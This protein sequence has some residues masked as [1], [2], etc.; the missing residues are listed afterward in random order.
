M[1]LETLTWKAEPSGSGH[2][3]WKG[4]PLLDFSATTAA[5]VV[6]WTVQKGNL[7]FPHRSQADTFAIGQ[8]SLPTGDKIF[9]ADV[10]VIEGDVVGIVLQ[11]DKSGAPC[12]GVLLSAQSHRIRLIYLPWPGADLHSAPAPVE[13][14]HT[15]HLQVGVHHHDDGTHFDILLDGELITTYTDSRNHPSGAHYGVMVNNSVARC[16]RLAVYARNA[17][18]GK[19]A[20]I[21]EDTFTHATT[22]DYSPSTLP[23]P[24]QWQDGAL[25]LETQLPSSGQGMGAIAQLMHHISS[26]RHVW[27]P[28]VSPYPDTVIGDHS[29]RSPAILLSDDKQALALIPDLDDVR[30]AQRSGWHV[31]LDYDHPNRTLRVAAGA[32]Q[33]GPFHVAYQPTPL[34]YSGQHVR[35]RLHVLI[36]DKKADIQNPYGMVA[37]WFWKQWGHDGYAAGG[38]QRTSF[39]KYSAYVVNWAFAPEPKGWGDTVWQQFTLNGQECGAPAFIVD[40]AQHPSV[41]LDKRRWRE[42]RSVWNQ[43]W[44][45]TQRTANGLL[46]YA[47]QIGS[48]DLEHRAHLMT[49]VALSAPQSDGLFPAVYTTGGGGYSLYK[50]SPGWEKAHWTNSDRRPPGVSP[51]ACHILDAA[52]TARLLLEWHDLNPKETAALAYVRGFVDRLCRLQRP[53]GAFPGWIEPNGT[54]APLLAEGPESAMSTTLLLDWARRFPKEAAVR[55]AARKGLAYLENGP[56]RDSRWEDFE[57][58]FSCSRWGE[59][60]IG[61]PITRN[62]VYKSNTFSPFWCAEAFLAASHVL[63]EPRYL[64]VGRR[65]LDELSLYQQVWEPPTIPAPTHGGFGVMNSD[66]EWNDARQSLFAPLY[67]AYYKETGDSEYFERG[68]S[69]LRASF[70]MMYCPENVEVKAAYERQHPFFGPESYGFMMENI[71]HGGPGP[72]PIGPFT[73]FTWG[74]GAALE[75]ASNVRDGYGDLYLDLRHRQVFGVDGC[76]AHL[77]ADTLHIQD[78]YQRHTLTLV[79]SKGKRLDVTLHDGRTVLSLKDLR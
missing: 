6:P 21:Q 70:A 26:A 78:R 66:G 35:I 64:T 77:E 1:S 16:E 34:T 61:Q 23:L 74:N 28:H 37:R 2:V 8:K 56:V 79:T 13:L 29:F 31:W 75:A 15:H 58:Y 9:E 59:D 42:Q 30:D 43:A 62:G 53:N 71:A 7:L 76:T 10:R 48:A 68:V 19:G 60:K 67:L 3:L 44:F 41:P 45:S 52:F 51:A 38:S 22:A 39:T 40:V 14:G 12:Y 65:C 24:A 17:E 50:D 25:T 33:V 20:L 57:T 32:Y 47:R 54:V 49:Q 5:P 63:H 27:I 72:D 11:A 55:E 73:I 18:G 4:A 69:A 36:S 46:R